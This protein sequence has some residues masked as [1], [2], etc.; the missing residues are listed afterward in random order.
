MKK[1]TILMA[2]LFLLTCCK[3]ELKLPENYD[4]EVRDELSQLMTKYV[5]AWENLDEVTFW[6]CFDEGYL[7]LH[8]NNYVSNLEQEIESFKEYF[9]A[10]SYEDVK[11]KSIDCVV[12]HNYAFEIGQMEYNS[13]NNEKQDTL[14]HIKTSGFFVYRKQE[15]GGWKIFRFVIKGSK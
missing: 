12:D 3:Q 2:L 15:E 6:S 4:A 14:I 5:E 7:R 13:I 10:Y 11:Y 8:S 9:V 1:V